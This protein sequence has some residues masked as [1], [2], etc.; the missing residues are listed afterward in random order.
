LG[1]PSRD[2]PPTGGSISIDNPLLPCRQV[3]FKPGQQV[4]L[5]TKMV[6]LKEKDS[7][8]NSVEGFGNVTEDGTDFLP[9]INGLTDVV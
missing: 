3:R 8:P 1:H 9:V 4:S 5:N 2:V 6:L 7:V